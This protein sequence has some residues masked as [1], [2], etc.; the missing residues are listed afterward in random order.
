M[1]ER[2]GSVGRI[3]LPATTNALERCCRAFQRFYATR[4]GVHAVLSATRARLLLLVVAVLTPQATT[5]HAPIDVIRPEARRMPLSRLINAPCRALQ[6]R[7]LVKP[8]AALADVLL[9][10]AAAA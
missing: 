7:E 3:R 4:R 10:R 6:E 5:G 8:A 1:P 9:P 2:I